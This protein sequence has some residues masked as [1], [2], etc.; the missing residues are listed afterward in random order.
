MQ[1]GVFIATLQGRFLDFNEALMRMTGYD[2][3]E[4]LMQVDI[5]QMLYVNPSER[6]RLKKLLHEHGSVNDFE[7]EIRRKDGELRTVSES[8][9]AVR[10]V[11]GTVT[12]YQ[13][14]LLDVTERRNA[15][16]EIRR[17]NRE[18]V[19]LNSLAESLVSSFDLQDSIHR[20]LRQILDLFSLDAASLYLFERDGITLK[21][22][23]SVGHRSEFSRNFP[24]VTISKELLQQI[25]SVRATFLTAQGLSTSRRRAG[26]SVE[27]RD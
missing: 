5:A 26:S 14:F 2:S 25:R 3:R 9:T 24:T 23:S 22:V 21:R 8:S 10:D 15:E 11:A 27:R 20:A 18:L 1:E 19:V 7:Y 12:A 13:G 17:R 16:Q 6:E 4:E